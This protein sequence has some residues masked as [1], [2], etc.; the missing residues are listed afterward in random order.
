ME[1]LVFEASKSVKN[2]DY[3]WIS[4]HIIACKQTATKTSSQH[5]M[6]PPPFIIANTVGG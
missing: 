4:E 2:F 5:N 3:K 1:V 6:T